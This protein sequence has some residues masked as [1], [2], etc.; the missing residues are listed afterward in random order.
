MMSVQSLMNALEAWVQEELL[1][2]RRFLELLETQE[3]AVKRAEAQGLADSVNAIEK[4]I[5][6][7]LRRDEKRVRLFAE[8]GHHWG[9]TGDVLTLTSIAERAGDAGRRLATL[10]DELAAAS[11]RIVR[12]NRRVS[13]LLEAHQK[14]IEELLQAL[15]AIQGGV[16]GGST[17]ALVNAEA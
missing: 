5:E 16:P 7:Q 12:K 13:R 11:D 14:V 4:E 1:A 10:R 6:A 3:A 15:V 2:R 9:V 17:G 8:L